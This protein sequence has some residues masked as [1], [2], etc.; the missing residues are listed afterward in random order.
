MELKINLKVGHLGPET[1]PKYFLNSSRNNFVYKSIIL[2][3]KISHKIFIPP[4][5]DVVTNIVIPGSC[6]NSDLAT[7]VAFVKHRL[8][9]IL[10]ENQSAGSTDDWLPENLGMLG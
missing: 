9:R 8:K 6:P 7:S 2:W 5:L 3:N 1:M 4:D 10:L